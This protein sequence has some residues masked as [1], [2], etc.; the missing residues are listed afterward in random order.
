MTNKL[1]KSSHARCFRILFINNKPYKR[2][3]FFGGKFETLNFD[4]SIGGLG[5]NMVLITVLRPQANFFQPMLNSY[6]YY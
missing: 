3:L 4:G 6:L 5:S 1:H 2:G